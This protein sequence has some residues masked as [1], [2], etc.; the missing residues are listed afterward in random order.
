MRPII[1]S[2]STQQLCASPLYH[3]FRAGKTRKFFSVALDGRRMASRY[4]VLLRCGFPGSLSLEQPA[5]ARHCRPTV[6]PFRGLD[7]SRPIAQVPPSHLARRYHHD[8]GPDCRRGGARPEDAEKGDTR[9]SP[10]ATQG[11]ESWP[12]AERPPVTGRISGLSCGSESRAST[13]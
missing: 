8:H 10:G 3:L 2:G 5:Q 13:W 12:A 9:L 6:R 1:S 11:R 4:R 7:C